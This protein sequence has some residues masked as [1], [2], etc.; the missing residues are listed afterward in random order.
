MQL[1]IE[2]D[3]ETGLRWGELTE[4]RVSDIDF[5]NGCVIIQ[6]V[7]IHLRSAANGN[8]PRFRVKHYPKDGEPRTVSLS[9]QLI[10]KLKTHIEQANLGPGDLLFW[11][12]PGP[13]TQPK[14][15]RE[16]LDPVTLGLTEPNHLG[17][18]YRHGTPT[19]YNAGCCRCQHCRNAIAAYRAAKREADRG[20]P[21]SLRRVQTDGHISNDWFRKQIWAKALTKANLGFHVTPHDLRH[22]HAS[23]L[24]AGGADLV[25]V[26][27]R[28]G[29]GTIRTTERYLLPTKHDAALAALAVVRRGPGHRDRPRRGYAG[30]GSCRSA[31]PGRNS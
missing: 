7:V 28:L 1:L 31:R 3:I 15:P 13:P 17:R 11:Y 26:K 29:H 16:P 14:R 4:L 10:D 6:R 24:L 19:A 18:Q 8:V 30:A 21:V 12:E 9:P 5:A 20:G 22:A 23:W 27:D 25:V 2:T